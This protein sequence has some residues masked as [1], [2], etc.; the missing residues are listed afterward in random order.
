MTLL[1]DMDELVDA[2]EAASIARV[3]KGTIRTWKHRKQLKVAGLNESGHQLFRVG[4]VF[5]AELATRRR[6]T[7]ARRSTFQ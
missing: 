3:S 5:R 7:N 1:P 6:Q 4:D 2:D